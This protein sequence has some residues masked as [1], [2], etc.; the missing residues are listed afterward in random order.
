MATIDTLLSELAAL[1]SSPPPALSSQENIDYGRMSLEITKR[2]KTGVTTE[3]S[4][5]STADLISSFK[6]L[7]DKKK[8]NADCN[9]TI[10]ILQRKI[11]KLTGDSA[12]GFLIDQPMI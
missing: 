8:A 11:I 9:K 7:S 5:V 2:L 10:L 1:R 12:L 4:T 6:V 3:Y